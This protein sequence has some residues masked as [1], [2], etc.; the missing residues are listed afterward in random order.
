MG[1]MSKKAVT[2]LLSLVEI[3]LAGLLKFGS[4]ILNP[5]PQGPHVAKDGRVYDH[6]ETQE[7]YDARKRKAAEAE[8]RRLCAI[9]KREREKAQREAEIRDAQEDLVRAA[10]GFAPGEGYIAADGHVY[11]KKE[12]PE[13]FHARKLKYL[14]KQAEEIRMRNNARDNE[15][16]MS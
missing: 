13:D 11:P 3:P 10:H 12:S 9:R 15:T 1:D 14:R 7:E 8:D 6:K 2:G 16:K 5:K 4:S